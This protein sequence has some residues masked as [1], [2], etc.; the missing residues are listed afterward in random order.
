M[1]WEEIGNNVLVLRGEKGS[2]NTGIVVANGI[3]FVIDPG[4][5]DD[6]AK[7]IHEKINTMGIA[8]RF[9][10]LTHAHVDHMAACKGFERVFAHRWETILA[11]SA[12]CRNVCEFNVVDPK[13][14]KFITADSVPV[15]DEIWWGDDILG[16]VARDTHGHT[17]GH[18]AFTYKEFVFAGDALFGDRLLDKVKILYH[19]DVFEAM[20]SLD[21]YL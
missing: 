5:G 12:T 11:E 1:G 21:E 3:A 17:P 2:P 9:A 15:T 10:I 16:I 18:T 4:M 7:K 8:R 13:G 19:T 6:R 20:K 14:F